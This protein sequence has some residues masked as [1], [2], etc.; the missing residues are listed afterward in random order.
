[1]RLREHWEAIYASRQ[2][3]AH[4]SDH[5]QG[6]GLESVKKFAKAESAQSS[7]GT[8]ALPPRSDLLIAVPWS[9]AP[10]LG[11]F[12]AVAQQ[13]SGRS[14]SNLDGRP[15]RKVVLGLDE[16][17]L[18]ARLYHPVTRRV[19]HHPSYASSY[20]SSVKSCSAPAQRERRLLIPHLSR[21][22]SK[23]EG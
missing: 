5:I 6:V 21:M 18:P 14:R 15:L 13:H 4:V 3:A 16:L 19:N 2:R 1:V 20:A 23:I 11:R 12:I 9:K 10:K 8:L 22:T 7:P 17:F